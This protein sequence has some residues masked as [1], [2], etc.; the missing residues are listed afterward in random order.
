MFRSNLLTFRRT[1]LLSATLLLLLLGFAFAACGSNTITGSG[2]TPL[3]PGATA[4]AKGTPASATGCPDKTVVSTPPATAQ[5]VVTS[6]DN[7][8]QV[9]ASKGETV[10]VDLPF[11]HLWQG[12]TGNSSA[13]LTPQSPSGYAFTT[14]QTCVWRFVAA[15]AG[16]THLSFTGRPICVMGQ[17]CP[18]YVMVVSFTLDVTE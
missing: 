2:N 12:P 5:V 10:E 14:R 16:T 18:M 17:A 3:T 11:G 7:N 15:G 9:N 4:T 1:S 13:V 8:T 6:S